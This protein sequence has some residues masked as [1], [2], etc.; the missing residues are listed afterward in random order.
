[1]KV[2]KVTYPDRE[3]LLCV[4]PTLEDVVKYLTLEYSHFGTPKIEEVTSPTIFE[5]F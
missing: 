2:F 3:I 5:M 1:M 4:Y